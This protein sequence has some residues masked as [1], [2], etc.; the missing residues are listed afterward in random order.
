MVAE[1]KHERGGALENFLKRLGGDTAT[2]E[3][4]RACNKEIHT[5]HGKGPGHFKRAVRWLREAENRGF[6][7]LVFLIDEDG[8]RERIAQIG[9]AQDSSLSQLSR[10]MGVAIRTFDAWL[11]ADEGT[12]TKVLGYQ[13][14]KQPDPERIRGP[15]AICADLLTC[16]PNRM[17][18][19]EMYARVANQ[20]DITVLSARCPSGF[21]PFAA[22]AGR[23]FE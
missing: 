21:A 9:E 2:F 23:I 16:S 6:D 18:Q 13:V 14:N 1:G 10:A 4:D 11:L 12:L 19:T 20:I 3:F 8:Q 5:F 15:K 7:A 17:T 22:R